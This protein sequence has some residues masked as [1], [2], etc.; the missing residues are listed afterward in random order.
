MLMIPFPLQTDSGARAARNFNFFR[1]LLFFRGL[2][3]GG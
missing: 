1:G 3:T 2:D